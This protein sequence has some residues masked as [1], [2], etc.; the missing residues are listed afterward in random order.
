[1]SIL[2]TKTIQTVTL[3]A[4]DGFSCNFQ[5]LLMDYQDSLMSVVPLQVIVLLV[6]F[7]KFCCVLFAINV[8][9]KFSSVNCILTLFFSMHTGI[10]TV[11]MLEY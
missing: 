6:V 7:T 1:M 8:Y 4:E 11:Q 5:S 10:W 3:V 9:C 2:F